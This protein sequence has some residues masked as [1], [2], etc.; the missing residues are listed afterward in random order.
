MGNIKG[1][2]VIGIVKA[3][4]A[5]RDA[6]LAVLPEHLHVYVA[7][8]LRVL[9]SSWYPDDHFLGL[10]EGLLR[11][12]PDTG[13]DQWAWL[14]IVGARTDFGDGGVY[15]AFVKP[16]DPGESLR[17]FEEVWPLYHDGGSAT[18]VLEPDS[19]ATVEIDHDLVTSDGFCRLQAAH[20][21]TLMHL[22]DGEQATVTVEQVGSED[23]PARM[24]AAW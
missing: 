2:A 3:L 18:V 12:L 6:A 13:K 23:S 5:H 15:A 11:V 10:A 17:R 8:Q 16:G 20:L 22:A 7:G 14:G 19:R 21:A 9:T 24:A 4:R 1:T